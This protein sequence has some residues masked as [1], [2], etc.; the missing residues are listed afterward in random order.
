LSFFPIFIFSPAGHTLSFS[1][2]V[3]HFS[4]CL[5]AGYGSGLISHVTKIIN[6]NWILGISKDC[7]CLLHSQYYLTHC[8]A[9]Y[10]TYSLATAHEIEDALDAL[11][12]VHTSTVRRIIILQVMFLQWAINMVQEKILAC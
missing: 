10:S 6:W 11:L 8:A 3:P 4:S 12:Y 1:A 7:L 5:L 9:Y 2:S